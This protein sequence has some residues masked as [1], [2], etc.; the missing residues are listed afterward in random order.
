MQPFLDTRLE[1]ATLLVYTTRS[2]SLLLDAQTSPTHG[3]VAPS[4]HGELK[5][6]RVPQRVPHHDRS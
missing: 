4:L 3:Q 6:V 1:L 5:R 2:L